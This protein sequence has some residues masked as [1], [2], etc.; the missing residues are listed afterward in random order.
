L[1]S[2]QTNSNSNTDPNARHFR[3]RQADLAADQFKTIDKAIITHSTASFK[4]NSSSPAQ[5]TKFKIQVKSWE[6]Q[7]RRP[8]YLHR[9]F[10]QQQTNGSSIERRFESG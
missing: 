10:F 2:L 3:Y 7:S 4:N 5:E 9:R 1:H 8:R 6:S